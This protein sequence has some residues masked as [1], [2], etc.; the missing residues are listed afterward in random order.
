MFSEIYSLIRDI[1]NDTEL[2]D[3]I[4]KLTGKNLAV[5]DAGAQVTSPS[6]KILFNG[7][8]ITRASNTKQAVSFVVSFMLP[9]WNAE[10]F[11][12]CLNFI[13]FVIPICFNYS[14]DNG[15][16]ISSIIPSISENSDNNFWVVN[17]N[18]TAFSFV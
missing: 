7:G 5:I 16:F 10:A 13:E 9:F 12:D 17:L 11:S 6:A 18:F 14:T 2:N 1:L 4:F 8:E 15:G 3:Y